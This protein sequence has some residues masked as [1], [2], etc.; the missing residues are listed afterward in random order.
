MHNG[1]S[2]KAKGLL[3]NVQAMTRMSRQGTL[4]DT[5]GLASTSLT[6][7]TVGIANCCIWFAC[8]H[9][10]RLH[11]WGWRHH[12]CHWEAAGYA[13]LGWPRRR[14]LPPL[15]LLFRCQSTFQTP[16][17]SSTSTS[18]TLAPLSSSTFQ[19]VQTQWPLPSIA[20]QSTSLTPSVS[21][22][23]EKLASMVETVGGLSGFWQTQVIRCR[24]AT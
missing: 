12:H 5:R 17:A 14:P 13:L 4:L 7:Q 24:V 10:S 19:P 11:L 6:H 8:R 21:M 16:I 9:Y 18:S 3:T 2:T 1:L 20:G 15:P 22:E 23:R